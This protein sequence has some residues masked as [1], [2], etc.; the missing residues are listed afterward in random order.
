MFEI[1][2]EFLQ[3]RGLRLANNRLPYNPKLD[4]RAKELRKN[5]TPAEKK[6]WF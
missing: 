5:M 3:K 2:S 4:E 1:T 6:L